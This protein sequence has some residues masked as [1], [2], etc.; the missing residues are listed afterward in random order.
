[1]KSKIWLFIIAKVL[2]FIAMGMGTT[3]AIAKAAR[4]FNV[5]ELEIRKKLEL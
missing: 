2:E 3:M 4:I 1:M 5:C